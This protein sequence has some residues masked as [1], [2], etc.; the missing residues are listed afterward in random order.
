MAFINRGLKFE[1]IDGPLLQ[2]WRDISTA[3]ASD[4][5][6]RGQAMT[7]DIKPLTPGMRICGQ[8]RTLT[9]MVGDSSGVHRALSLLTPGNVLVMNVGGYRDAACFGSMAGRVA[10]NQGAEG[11]VLDGATRDAAELRGLG[12]PVFCAGITPRGPHKGFGGVFDDVA[13]VGGVTV[14]PGDIIIGDDDGVVVVPLARLDE[15]L[16]K[17]RGIKAEEERWIAEIAGGR[18]TAELLKLNSG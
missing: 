7:S 18:T 17:A 2:A 9:A 15:A 11:V 10:I 12:L 4:V 8:A 3:V 16:E 13:S 5:L 1:R 14:A 6:N